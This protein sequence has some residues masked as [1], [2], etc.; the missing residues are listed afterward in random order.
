MPQIDQDAT[1]LPIESSPPRSPRSRTRRWL[2]LTLLAMPFLG[3]ATVFLAPW[4]FPGPPVGHFIVTPPRPMDVGDGLI[5]AVRYTLEAR[6]SEQ[7]TFFDFSRGSVVE[8]PHQFG[9]DWDLAFQRHKILANGGATNPKGKGALLDLGDVPFDEVVEAPA[10]G[11][12]EDTIASITPQTI[13]TENLAI[14]AWYRY[15]FLTHVLRPKPNVYVIR[16]AD[17]KYAKMR[18]ISYYCDGGQASG[19]FTIEYVYQGDG[20]RRFVPNPALRPELGARP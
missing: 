8:V 16:T 10:E 15:N 9:I 2:R 3:L 5:G 6:A 14:K 12:V 13:I 18:L 4:L 20:S 19:C 1:K 11:Y 7:W 17:G